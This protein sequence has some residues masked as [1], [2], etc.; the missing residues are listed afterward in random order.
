MC[1]TVTIYLIDRAP[2]DTQYNKIC[3]MFV[4]PR[5]KLSYQHEQGKLKRSVF[6]IL[7]GEG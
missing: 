4:V 6:N 2:K 7:I 1:K 3:Q 5:S